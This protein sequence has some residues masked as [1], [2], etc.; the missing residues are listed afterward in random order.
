[1][2]WRTLWMAHLCNALHFK[3]TMNRCFCL[4]FFPSSSS[5]LLCTFF[6]FQHYKSNL[7]WYH[8]Y[9]AK[10][11]RKSKRLLDPLFFIKWVII[12]LNYDSWKLEVIW[13]TYVIKLGRFFGNIGVKLCVEFLVNLSQLNVNCSLAEAHC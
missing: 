4:V 5:L 7:D 1:M 9:L 3:I 12:C 6:S 2:C 10:R 13:Q 11:N 8:L